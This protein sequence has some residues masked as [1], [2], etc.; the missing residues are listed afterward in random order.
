MGELGVSTAGTGRDLVA[1]LAEPDRLVTLSPGRLDAVLRLA[2]RTSTLPRLALGVAA[3]DL[4]R[5][6]DGKAVELLEAARAT[7]EHHRRNLLWEADRIAR[8][9]DPLEIRVVALKG[10]AYELAGLPPA[11][12]RMSSDFDVLVPEDRLEPVERAL[13]RAGWRSDCD[14]AYDQ[15]YYRE[16]MHE[17]PP[18][19]HEGRGTLVDVHHTLAPRTSREVRPDVTALWEDARRMD[20]SPFEVLGPE[21]LVVHSAIH[22]FH[23]GDLSQP[24]RDLLDLDDLLRHFGANSPGFWPRI[25]RRAELHRAARPLYYALRY[26]SRVLGTPIPVETRRAVRA[27]APSPSV[28]AWMDRLVGEV[29]FPGIDGPAPWSTTAAATALYVRSQAL[30]MPAGRL[31]LHLARKSWR[32]ARHGD[33]D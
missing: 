29:L 4:D 8:A 30:R 21:D 23:D 19:R 12:G 10:A 16:W 26:S 3:R 7:A 9:L 33:D 31:G 32:R 15:R 25:V 18:L 28:G 27:W 22:A 11:I 6:L 1:V 13:A 14:D 20:D 17:L 5:G 24:L 2:R